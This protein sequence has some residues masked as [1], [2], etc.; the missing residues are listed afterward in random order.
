MSRK[1]T[2]GPSP[3]ETPL[4]KSADLLM[5]RCF[6]AVAA[7]VIAGGA[8]GA[9]AGC[10]QALAL[11][12]LADEKSEPIYFAEKDAASILVGEAKSVALGAGDLK[13]FSYVP[14]NFWVTVSRERR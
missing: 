11:I 6:S 10:D 8:T 7:S 14:G 2:G 1:K 4:A 12:G 5:K 13:Y 9:L 3:R